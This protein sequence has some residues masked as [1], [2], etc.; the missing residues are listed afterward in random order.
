MTSAPEA[1]GGPV[2]QPRYVARLA[3]G[4]EDLDQVRALREAA[5]ALAAPDIDPLDN[6]CLQ[7]VIEDRRCGQLVG[8]FRMLPLAQG[9]EIARSY[10]AR[11]YDLTRLARLPG[12][13]TEL[14]RFCIRPGLRDPDILRAAWAA[15]TAHVDRGG[16]TMLFGCTSFRGTDPAPYAAAFAHL[17]AAH[18]APAEWAP[19]LRARATVPLVAACGQ[20]GRRGALQAMPPLLRTYLAMG[21]K[22][23]DHAVI[24]ARMKSLHVFTGLEITA[25]PPMRQRLLRA[26]AEAQRGTA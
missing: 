3:C 7:I 26:D 10:S 13:M 1:T 14:G 19:G 4:A 18:L 23:S 22:V 2:G 5:F 15:I 9:A 8:C 21:G 12:P 24:D 20:A 6:A 16:V 25:I 17:A 11:F